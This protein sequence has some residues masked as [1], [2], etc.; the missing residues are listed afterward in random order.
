MAHGLVLVTVKNPPLFVLNPLYL[1][2]LCLLAALRQSGGSSARR[3]AVVLLCTLDSPSHAA[4]YCC[5]PGSDRHSPDL[6]P[7]TLV[8]VERLSGTGGSRVVSR[9]P[10]D[11]HLL[12]VSVPRVGVDVQRQI[13]VLYAEA[14]KRRE[15]AEADEDYLEHMQGQSADPFAPTAGDTETHDQ[16]ETGD[17]RDSRAD[18]DSEAPDTD[19]NQHLP[20]DDESFQSED[21]DGASLQSDGEES[22]EESGEDL[23]KTAEELGG[24]SSS[25][26]THSRRAKKQRGAG[27]QDENEEVNL[28]APSVQTSDE[29]GG[30]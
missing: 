25:C 18:S 4:I 2:S 21:E 3:L 10:Q 26:N 29:D 17:G 27:L 20:T 6:F 13:A 14:L 23:G 19:K 16:E 1:R 28:S 9:N 15:D 30:S 5:T 12:H 8:A 22:G 11:M 7:D 24:E